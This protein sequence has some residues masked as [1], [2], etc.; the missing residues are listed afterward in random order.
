LTRR[1][2]GRTYECVGE[3]EEK[4]RAFP[5]FLD[6]AV[7]KVAG[8]QREE[9][10]ALVVR[11]VDGMVVTC[12]DVERA[13]ELVEIGVGGLVQ[14]FNVKSTLRGLFVTAKSGVKRW[15]VLEPPPPPLSPPRPCQPPRPRYKWQCIVCAHVN[16][17]SKSVC[18]GCGY[19]RKEGPMYKDA[20][21]CL[22]KK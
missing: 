20:R 8:L 10:G 5:F 6:L 9:S 15:L 12:V 14:L 2:R 7:S 1:S 16:Y 19:A 18:F 22:V 21:F 17:P 11:F 13:K 4:E 3:A